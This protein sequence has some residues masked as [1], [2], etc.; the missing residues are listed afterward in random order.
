MSAAVIKARKWW[1]SIC[2]FQT[3]KITHL[4]SRSVLKQ[5]INNWLCT[6]MLSFLLVKVKRSLKL[7]N[8]IV[9]GLKLGFGLSSKV[10]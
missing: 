1:E 3:K 5:V 7:K 9:R 10:S 8:H 4:L 6:H 2:H